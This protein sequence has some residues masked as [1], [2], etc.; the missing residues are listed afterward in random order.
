MQ[1]YAAQTTCGLVRRPRSGSRNVREAY[2]EQAESQTIGQME[3]K[4]ELGFSTRRLQS[5][6]LIVG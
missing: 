6:R 3:L 5:D 2:C 1:A 4:N